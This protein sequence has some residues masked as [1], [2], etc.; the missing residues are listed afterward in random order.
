MQIFDRNFREEYLKPGY[1]DTIQS[2]IEPKSKLLDTDLD[3]E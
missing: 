2:D 3:G 1:E